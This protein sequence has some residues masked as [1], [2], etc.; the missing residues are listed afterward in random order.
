MG[1]S[2]KESWHCLSGGEIQ[3]QSCTLMSGQSKKEKPEKR[4]KEIAEKEKKRREQEGNR[5][6]GKSMKERKGRGD[7]KKLKRRLNTSGH[8][9]TTIASMMRIEDLCWAM[10]QL[11]SNSEMALLME[12]NSNLLETA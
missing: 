7:K 3:T 9:P 4:L 8:L 12:A 11:I 2:T 6:K 10:T 1:S 5:N